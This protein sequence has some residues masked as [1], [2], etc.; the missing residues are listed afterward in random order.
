MILLLHLQVL[1]QQHPMVLHLPD[2][3]E[4][5]LLLLLLLR[6]LALPEEAHCGDD[7]GV[8]E[9]RVVLLPLHVLLL[10]VEFVLLQ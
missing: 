7:V 1:F 9:E 5:D 10:V 4:E 8:V 3:A 6:R 2:A